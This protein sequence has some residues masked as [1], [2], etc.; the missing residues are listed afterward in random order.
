MLLL[1]A[2]AA[3]AAGAVLAVKRMT[4]RPSPTAKPPA[5][6][7]DLPLAFIAFLTFV[8]LF[9][10]LGVGGA[11]ASLPQGEA[12]YEDAMVSAIAEECL[13]GPPPF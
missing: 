12:S 1:V 5:L 10:W 3:V 7:D 8:A 6:K 9:H 2:T 13:T 4:A 11:D